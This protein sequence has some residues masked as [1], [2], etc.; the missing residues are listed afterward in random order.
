[1]VFLN[2]GSYGA[3]PREV[4]EEATRWRSRMEAQPVRFFNDELPAAIR[5]A[6]AALARFVGVAPERLGFVEN[7]SA[8]T[9]AVLASLPWS[10]GDEVLATSHTYNAVR[11]NLRHLAATRGVV[12][13]EAPVPFPVPDEASAVAAIEGA[14]TPRT[15]LLLLDHIASASAVVFPLP[16][17]VALARQRGIPVLVDGAHGPGMLDLDLDALGADWYVGNCHKWMCAPKGAGFLTVSADAPVPVHPTV[18][19]HSYGQGFAAEFDKIGTRDCSAW[20]AVPAAIALHE[21]L[22]GAA[23][24]TRNA[25]LARSMARQVAG[26]LRTETGAPDAMTGAIACVRLPWSGPAD[27]PTA[28]VLRTRLW[29]AEQIELHVTSMAGALWA[30]ISAAPYNEEADAE[31]LAAALQRTLRAAA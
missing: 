25:A 27:W 15:R 8:G 14:I 9:N 18:I 30:R 1:M 11:N 20:L 17:L 21:R 7:A 24:R 10:A 5:E 19:S 23:L 29:Q 22:G 12:P 4:Q 6:A 13:V 2:H 28:R 16:R 31:G 26:E 3:T